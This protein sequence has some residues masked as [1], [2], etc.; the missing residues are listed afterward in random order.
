MAS[1]V[2]GPAGSKTELAPEASSSAESQ[3]LE[4]AIPAHMIPLCL[5]LGGGIQRVYKCQVEGCM[6]GP[7]ASCAVIC[8]HVHRE[9]LGVGLACP[10]CAKTFFNSDTLRHH[11]KSHS[12]QYI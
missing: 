11:K 4:V 3:A 12:S 7:S 5:Q 6:E 1:E 10:L 2:S 8:T 9:H